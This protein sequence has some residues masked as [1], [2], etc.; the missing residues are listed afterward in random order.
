MLVPVLGRRAM[1]TFGTQLPDGEEGNAGSGLGPI[2]REGTR[3]LMLPTREFS[4]HL[5][6]EIAGIRLELVHLPSK[7]DDQIA[8]WLPGDK[9]LISA[10]II[11]GQT[12]PNMYAIRGNSFRSPMP[13]V[14]A[15]DALRE[16]EAEI[17][18]PH[19]GEPVDGAAEVEDMLT[20]HR[21]A[22]QYLHDQTVRRMNLGWTPDE[23]A[24]KVV[25]PG[26]LAAHPWLGD[27]TVPTNTA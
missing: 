21:D 7:T 11:Q 9:V 17:L 25:M 12:L 18:S 10:D 24:E 14:R 2:N 20:A 19:H 15:V 23:I 26:H 3:G 1:Y 6:L 8:V 16:H 13:W 5:E 4:G 27:T 22:M